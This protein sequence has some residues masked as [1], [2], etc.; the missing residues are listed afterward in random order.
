VY[1]V[2]YK[3]G[4]HMNCFVASLSQIIHIK[5]FSMLAVMYV[6]IHFT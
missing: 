2:S 4:Y 1:C 3:M 6:L 5:H